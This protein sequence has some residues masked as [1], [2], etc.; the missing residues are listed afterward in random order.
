MTRRLSTCYSSSFSTF[1]L[2]IIGLIQ[3]E[4]PRL[5]LAV[6]MLASRSY[7][8]L[9][10]DWG[11][12]KWLTRRNPPRIIALP[13]LLTPPSQETC[14]FSRYSRAIPA[15]PALR[16]CLGAFKLVKCLP[17]F[18]CL[19]I[20]SQK[21]K[22]N[23]CSPRYRKTDRPHYYYNHHHHYCH[24]HHQLGKHSI[25]VK[26]SVVMLSSQRERRKRDGRFMYVWM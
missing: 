5:P 9:G 12:G 7:L 4:A 24:C 19:R 15:L 18:Q 20:K 17:T 1:I 25:S 6:R 10:R 14:I 16:A 21:N 23:K 2:I 8:N 11:L 13:N 22:Q 26:T 3:P